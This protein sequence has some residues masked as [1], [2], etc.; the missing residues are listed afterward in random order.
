MTFFFSSCWADPGRVIAMSA[1]SSV[2]HSAR[3][4]PKF[5]RMFHSQVPKDGKLRLIV[6]FFDGAIRQYRNRIVN[7]KTPLRRMPQ[8]G[9]ANRSA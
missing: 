6:C 9:S 5:V 1:A 2:E 7:V 8:P 4:R 3:P